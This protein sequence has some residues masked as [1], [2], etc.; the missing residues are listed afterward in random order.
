[1][2]V[3]PQDRKT[4]IEW[5][6]KEIEHLESLPTHKIYADAI[7]RLKITKAAQEKKLGRIQNNRTQ[8]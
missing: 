5:L 1:M 6:G 2:L 8:I 4:L 7:S 3:T